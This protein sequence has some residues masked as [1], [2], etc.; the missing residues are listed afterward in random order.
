MSFFTNNKSDRSPGAINGNPLNGLCEKVCVQVKK[1]FDA[2]IR[3]T[4]EENVTIVLKNFVPEKPAQP[5]TFISCRSTSPKGIVSNLIID[6][7]EEKPR[8]ARVR[9]TVT[10][11]M[12]CIFVDANGVEG[13][14]ATSVSI[15]EDIILF[16]PEPSIIP[17]QFEAVVSAVALDGVPAGADA[18]RCNVCITVILKVIIE[19]ELLIP[20]YG[21]CHI[22][23]CQEF[24]QEVCSGFFE[25]PL[26]PDS[27][28]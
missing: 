24:T 25:L 14:A 2:C 19:T 6:R 11:P 3:Q 21:Y 23:P 15:N 28:V 20:S 13:K 17:Y 4:Q 9:C 18:F 16:V 22:P 5:L 1:V 7:L 26:Y 10:L 27:E 12:E 8:Q